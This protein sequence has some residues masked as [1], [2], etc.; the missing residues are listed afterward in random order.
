MP[1]K[2]SAIPVRPVSDAWPPPA[3]R[4]TG[5]LVGTP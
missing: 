1:E 4:R 2:T 5:A 3:S